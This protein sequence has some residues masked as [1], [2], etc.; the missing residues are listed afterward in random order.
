M[1]DGRVAESAAPTQ[2]EWSEPKKRD[3]GTREEITSVAI[4]AGLCSL[5][6]RGFGQSSGARRDDDA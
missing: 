3:G 5:V 4:R 2:R 1:R 6:S